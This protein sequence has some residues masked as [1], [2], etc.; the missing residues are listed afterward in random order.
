[1]STGDSSMNK[2][3]HISAFTFFH[4]LRFSCCHSL[5]RELAKQLGD[6][7]LIV[8]EDFKDVITKSK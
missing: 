6:K 8:F 4:I 2:L 5:N 1:M 3:F 7:G